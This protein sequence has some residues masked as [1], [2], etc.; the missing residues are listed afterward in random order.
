MFMSVSSKDK[1]VTYSYAQKK[2]TKKRARSSKTPSVMMTIASDNEDD[3]NYYFD[4][5]RIGVAFFF[6][7]KLFTISTISATA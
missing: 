7:K 4:F 2:K 5:L 3:E 1:K 6:N